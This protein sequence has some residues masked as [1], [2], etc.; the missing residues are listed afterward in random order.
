MGITAVFFLV[1]FGIWKDGTLLNQRIRTLFFVVVAL[2]GVAAYQFVREAGNTDFSAVVAAATALVC[3]RLFA[4]W[5]S[6]DKLNAV[7]RWGFFTGGVAHSIC[8]FHLFGLI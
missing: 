1:M 8:A 4:F 6:E 7:L 2:N 3:V 5:N